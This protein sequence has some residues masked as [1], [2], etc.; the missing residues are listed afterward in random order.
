[1]NIRD[2]NH[3]RAAEWYLRDT[4]PLATTP[5]ILA[6]VDHLAGARAGAAAQRAWRD[7]VASG[8]Y[9][10]AWWLSAARDTVDAVARYENLGIGLAEASLVALASRIS[11]VGI[12]TFDER[13]FRAIRPDAGGDSSRL[14]PADAP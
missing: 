8:V 7:D 12:A 6:E 11:T 2:R 3:E 9:D 13:H 14:L 10:V 4:P 1:V 5:L